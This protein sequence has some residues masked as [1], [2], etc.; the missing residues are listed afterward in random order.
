[1]PLGE[2]RFRREWHKWR[3]IARGCRDSE[4]GK[5]SNWMPKVA[6]WRMAI[7]AKMAV[8]AKTAK[9][10]QRAG[11]IQ[12]VA[13]IQIGC[14]KW[15]L[16]EWQFWRKWRIWHKWRKIARGLVRSRTWQIFKLDAKSRPL[17]SADF[18]KICEIDENSP[19]MKLVMS[20]LGN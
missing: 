13:K 17:E 18:G 5:Y 8:L 4:C 10:R 6:P 20:K 1:M 12:N 16:G 2:W 7:L 19:T 11:K 15:P 9:N 3:K 14:Q